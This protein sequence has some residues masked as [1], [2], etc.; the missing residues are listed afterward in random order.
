MELFNCQRTKSGIDMKYLLNVHT[1]NKY[2][3][4]Q[5]NPVSGVI[6]ALNYRI[7]L[8]KDL[9]FAKGVILPKLGNIFVCLNITK[10]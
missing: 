4:I 5:I 10:M 9:V 2:T 8:W 6:F 7:Y 1:D 3:D